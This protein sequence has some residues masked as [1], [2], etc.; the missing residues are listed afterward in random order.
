MTINEILSLDDNEISRMTERELRGVVG[1]LRHAV[2][3]RYK[4]TSKFWET[5]AVNGLKNSG[6]KITTRGKDLNG[7]R[8][9][10]ARGRTFLNAKTST[11]TG[12]RAVVADVKKRLG[13]TKKFSRSDY[14]NFWNLYSR[15]TELYSTALYGSVQIQHL[16][17]D[18]FNKNLS[19]D[20]I[21]KNVVDRLVSDYE[22]TADDSG[23]F[24]SE[25][26]F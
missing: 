9:E 13:I 17:A 10:L 8:A 21:F 25:L 20:D 16:I 7:L 6:G 3:A 22:Q 12:A 18:D 4:T 19:F 5:P 11:V 15:I 23:D 26:G 1:D 24:W 2:N 14:E